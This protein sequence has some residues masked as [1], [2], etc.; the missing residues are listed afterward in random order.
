M[1]G[2]LGGARNEPAYNTVRCTALRSGREEDAIS[3]KT[4]GVT[5][6]SEEKFLHCQKQVLLGA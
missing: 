3:R 1:T 5:E 2:L 4:Q 6:E